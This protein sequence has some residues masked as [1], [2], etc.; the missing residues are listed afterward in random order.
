[1]G[2]AS[3]AGPV[4]SSVVYFTRL[5]VKFHFHQIQEATSYGFDKLHLPISG[6]PLGVRQ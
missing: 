6:G 2:T 5:F 1:M 4:A 3:K